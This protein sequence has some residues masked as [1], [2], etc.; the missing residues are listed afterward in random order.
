MADLAGGDNIGTLQ[1]EVTIGGASPD[2]LVGAGA[3]FTDSFDDGSLSTDYTVDTTNAGAA[4]TEGSGVLSLSSR[5][6]VSTAVEYTPTA[7]TPITIE[8]SLQFNDTNDF[9]AIATRS[10]GIADPGNYNFITNGVYATFGNAGGINQMAIY[11]VV[12]G[13]VTPIVD[14]GS[15]AFT[16]NNGTTYDVAVT[17]DGLNLSITVT[18]QNNPSNTLT[19][20]GQD[21]TE[22]T[23]N[24]ISFLNRENV[25]NGPQID[26]LEITQ[27]SGLL[28]V[29]EDGSLSSQI[30]AGDLDNLPGDLNFTLDAGAAHG[31]VDVQPDG[32]FTYTPNPD[33]AGG[34]SFTVTVDDGAGGTNTR[35]ILLDVQNTNDAPEILGAQ[36]NVNTVQ[37]DGI[38]DYVAAAHD[39]SFNPGSGGL[40][41]ET[42]FYYDGTAPVS[43][44]RMIGKGYLGSADEGWAINLGSDGNLS[45]LVNTEDAAV[46]GNK[47]A[48]DF[49][50]SGLTAGWHHV[51]LVIDQSGAEGTITGYLDGSTDGWVADPTVGDTFTKAPIDNTDDV[52]VASR[53]DGSNFYA[54]QLDDI[55][56]WS[57]ARTAQEIADNRHQADLADTTDLAARYTLDNMDAADIDPALIDISGNGHQISAGGPPSDP[58]GAY[59][60]LDGTGDMVN[61]TQINPVDGTNKITIAAWVK[62]DDLTGTQAIAA[63]GAGDLVFALNGNGLSFT[64]AGVL[65]SAA[66]GTLT[67]GEW[68]HVAVTYDS[69]TGTFEAFV[70]GTLQGAGNVGTNSLPAATTMAIG[71]SNGDGN[72]TPENSFAGGIAQ[73]RIFDEVR[74]PTDIQADMAQSHYDG[75]APATLINELS[76][77][78]YGNDGSLV[79]DAQIVDQSPLLLGT[80]VTSGAVTFDGVD[81]VINFGQEMAFEVDTTFT[82]EAWINPNS[83]PDWASIVGN[84]TDDSTYESGYGLHLGPN[85]AVRFAFTVDGTL[86]VIDTPIGA[87]NLNQWSHVAATYDGGTARIFVNG[88]EVK[89]QDISGSEM[90]YTYPN[91]MRIG[92]YHDSDED[93]FFDGEIADVRIWDVARTGWEIDNGLEEPIP[94]NSPGL[95]FN[96]PLNEGAG[97]EPVSS[98]SD[99]VNAIGGIP[100]GA[101]VY[102]DTGPGIY[103]GLD[104]AA[105]LAGTEDTI[106][107][108]RIVAEDIDGD[109]LT[110]TLDVNAANGTVAL[111]PDGSYEY[112]PD[113]DTFGTDSFQVTVSD[114]FGGTDTRTVYLDI[115]PVT[116]VIIGTN[117]DDPNLLGTDGDDILDGR[118]GKNVMSGGGG[119]DYLTGGTRGNPGIDRNIAD[120]SDATAGITVDA[121]TDTVTGDASVG[122]DTLGNIDQINGSIHDDLFDMTGWDNGQFDAFDPD[123]GGGGFVSTLGVSNTVRGGDGDDTITGNGFTRAD[124]SDATGGVTATLTVGTDGDGTAT[125]AG[126]GTDT[127]TGGVNE[128]AGSNHNDILTGNDNNNVLIGR[129]GDDTLDGG[130]GG[131]D[132]DR[133]DYRNAAGAITVNLALGS[134]QVTNDGDGGVDTLIDI[135]QIRG[136]QFADSFIG[137]S[138]ANRFRGEGGAD[139]FTGGAGNDR[140]EYTRGDESVDVAYDTITDFN[141]GGGADTIRF[142]GMDGL[143][144]MTVKYTYA[145][146]IQATVDA[147]A[148]DDG[149]QDRVVFFTDDT[150][151]WIYVK[152]R[153]TGTTNY[154][155]TLIKL[156]GVTAPLAAGDVIGAAGA[157]SVT[158]GGTDTIIATAA[159]ETHTG[160]AGPDYFVFTA[161]TDSDVG[162]GNRDTIDDFVVGVDKIV[163][164]GLIADGV[165]FSYE[166][167]S[168]LGGLDDDA[169][170]GFGLLGYDDVLQIDLDGDYVVL[171]NLNID[172]Q[173]ELPGIDRNALTTDDFILITTGTAGDDSFVGRTGNDWILASATTSTAMDVASAAVTTGDTITLAGGSD[174]IDT[175]IFRDPMEFVGAE[176]S[177]SDLMFFY[178]DIGSGYIHKT[179]VVNHAA[180]SL[181][182]VEFEFK[183]G[184]ELDRF[185]VASG[186]DASAGAVNTLV[187]G[188]SGID[189]LIGSAHDDILLGNGGDDDLSGGGGDDLLIGGAGEDILDGG[190]GNDT[191]SYFQN[192]TGGIIV[193]LS[194]STEDAGPETVAGGTAYDPYSGET[195]TLSNIENAEGSRFNDFLIGSDFANR[196]SGDSGD[197]TIYGGG[198]ADILEGGG[199]S[200]VFIYGA[201]TESGLGSLLRDVIL[202][203]DAVGADKIDIS[204]FNQGMFM[205]VGDETNDFAGFGDSSAR[206]NNQTKILEIDA[207]GDAQADM[208][209]ELQNVEGGDLSTSDFEVGGGQIA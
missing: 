51:A 79:G 39:P 8:T 66:S 169:A 25:A 37:F 97:G 144:L 168:L 196:L 195:D 23:D 143:E 162:S 133:A 179:T 161:E 77:D 137:D 29:P 138:G 203:F 129:G 160:G 134:G 56:I 163:L 118:T 141:Q 146:A 204:A 108:G 6:I 159:Q 135:E 73:V 26:S 54:G 111:N 89:T 19:L 147:I 4:A 21:P 95:V 64:N 22:F 131:L 198:G 192:P 53:G 62:P 107:R 38:D 157:L 13:T 24:H 120:Y 30:V 36:A 35:T 113:P 67:A 28:V 173:I 78:G 153:G 85:E 18:E 10:D 209:I 76:L 109:Y 55:R 82:L 187:V 45:V 127:F 125:G 122:T 119:N 5:A 101:P 184:A 208:E 43:D 148:I 149:V 46:A 92:A 44:Q 34:D 150:D 188:G 176:W 191:V 124:Y 52:Y 207:D 80:N 185:A 42:W 98:I 114:G 58:F 69:T 61:V 186:S 68:N 12:G 27:P 142:N 128:L 189:T 183:D 175:L 164:E 63:I 91:D 126:V 117:G 170:A 41:V 90:T 60:A 199:D 145:G 70:N 174:G 158:T 171:G 180:N 72:Q 136:S 59:A 140:F 96:A 152:G 178:E 83:S 103:G 3:S 88:I 87:I 130:G 7:T 32:T 57:D 74:Q 121:S 202:D 200:D 139:T 102:T 106:L 166:G 115:A 71:S 17:D 9:M 94:A 205:F 156:A 206:F 1:G 14:T 123:G 2:F 75:Q 50:L 193:N 48:Q 31:T 172:M 132:I 105:P 151:G 110:F 81:D 167:L 93:Y 197:D 116:D 65:G 181:D 47:A 201:A 104:P 20:T 165:E 84:V 194:D 100:Y 154:D 86:H 190:D 177:G 15:G 11:R 16:F 33:Y 49:D 99:A 155:G 182:Y 112:T 40:T